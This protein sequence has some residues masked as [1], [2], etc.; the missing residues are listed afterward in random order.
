MRLYFPNGGAGKQHAGYPTR[1]ELLMAFIIEALRA[2][3]KAKAIV[4]ACMDEAHRGHAIYEHCQDNGG[5]EYVARQAKRAQEMI[6]DAGEMST[7]LGNARR[8]VRLHGNDLRFV[9]GRLRHRQ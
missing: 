3:I 2:K 6:R 8:L 9:P 7:D 1:S 5:G 4:A